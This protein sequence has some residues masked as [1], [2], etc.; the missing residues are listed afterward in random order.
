MKVSRQAVRQASRH[1]GRQKADRQTGAA[2]AAGRSSSELHRERTR[3]LT[4][5]ARWSEGPSLPSVIPVQAFLGNRL[6]A[7]AQRIGV[8]RFSASQVRRQQH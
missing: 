7:K 1:A 4:P 3:I 5:R 8:D 6:F 2:E